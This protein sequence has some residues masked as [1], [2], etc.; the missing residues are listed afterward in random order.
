MPGQNL[1]PPG[2]WASLGLYGTQRARFRK[3]P[4]VSS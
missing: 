4:F 2:M 1:I 3:P